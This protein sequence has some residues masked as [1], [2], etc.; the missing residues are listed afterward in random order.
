MERNNDRIIFRRLAGS[1][2]KVKK[3]IVDKLPKDCIACPLANEYQ[4]G[5]G[6]EGSKNYNGALRKGKKPDRRCKLV[7]EGLSEY[8]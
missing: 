2:M 7:T 1:R 5:C 3:V 8:I 4:K 6:K